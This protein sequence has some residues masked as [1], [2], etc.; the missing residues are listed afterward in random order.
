M[1]NG[2]FIVYGEEFENGFKFIVWK[3][4]IIWK[5]VDGNKLIEFWMSYL[6]WRFIFILDLICLRKVF[7]I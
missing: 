7:F 1:C 5:I 4:V 2:G 3:V 6:M